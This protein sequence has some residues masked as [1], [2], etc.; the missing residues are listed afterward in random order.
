M[1]TVQLILIGLFLAAAFFA[2]RAAIRSIQAS[3]RSRGGK[4]DSSLHGKLP[5][6]GE[7]GTATYRQKRRIKKAGFR[8]LK[9]GKL[10]TEQAHL[11]LCCDDYIDTLWERERLE[12]KQSLL[13]EDKEGAIKIILEHD[14]YLE[15]VV[16]WRLAHK[17]EEDLHLPKDPCR[18]TL[19]YF[20]AERTQ[21]RMSPQQQ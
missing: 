2:A 18:S 12:G 13:S 11:I 14:D 17:V 19:S 10:S 4:T 15:R 1:T 9:F 7:P 21:Q 3:L 6:I 8:D 20:L 5:T 16:T